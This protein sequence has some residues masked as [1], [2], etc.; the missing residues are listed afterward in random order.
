ML[1]IERRLEKRDA[2]RHLGQH[3]IVAVEEAHLDR[4]RRLG[5][6]QLRASLDDLAAPALVGVRVEENLARA[7]LGTR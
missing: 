6:I 7:E 4:G 3:R 2:S 1:G 5:A